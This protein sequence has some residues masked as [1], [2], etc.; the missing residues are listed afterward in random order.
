MEIPLFIGLCIAVI[1]IAGFL[2]NR[3]IAGDKERTQKKRKEYARFRSVFRDSFRLL[4]EGDACGEKRDPD[5]TQQA[6]R[7]KNESETRAN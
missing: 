1:L 3:E 6:R 2:A 4:D 7:D 5:C